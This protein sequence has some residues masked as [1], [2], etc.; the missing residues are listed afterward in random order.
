MLASGGSF[1]EQFLHRERE[2]P[3]L[4]RVGAVFLFS[5]LFIIGMNP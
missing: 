5:S 1:T 4:R 3:D 2:H